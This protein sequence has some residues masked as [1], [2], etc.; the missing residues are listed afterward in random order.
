MK[1]RIIILAVLLVVASLFSIGRTFS[2]YVNKTNWDYSYNSKD[3]YFT[4]NY[5]TEEEST[6]IYN[7]WDGSDITFNISNALNSDTYTKENITYEV[8]C[9]S[10]DTT[11]K[12]NGKSS[13]TSVLT[14][15]TYSNEELKLTL[16]EF[17]S[18]ANVTVVARSIKPY[19]KTL[20]VTFDIKKETLINDINYTLKKYDNL[21]KLLI[22]NNG[23]T[24]KCININ[25]L[26]SNIRVSKSTD[27]NNIKTNNDVIKSF[28]ITLNSNENKTIDLYGN[29]ITDEDVVV[30]FC[31]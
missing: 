2:K 25:I 1:K 3:F 19:K 14:G 30:G 28:E 5:L 29:G 18:N 31:D 15:N 23:N 12:I 27:M 22:N 11:C 7:S 6:L 17:E 16:G 20:Q 24:E 9:L 26:K 13:V 10:G 8:S 4:S 21:S